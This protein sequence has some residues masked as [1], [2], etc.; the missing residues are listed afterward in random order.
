MRCHPF[1]KHVNSEHAGDV[2][3]RQMN[4][5]HEAFVHD[6][7]KICELWLERPLFRVLFDYIEDFPEFQWDVVVQIQ[8][9]KSGGQPMP[10][11]S[12]PLSPADRGQGAPLHTFRE[13]RGVIVNLLEH[14]YCRS[15]PFAVAWQ[16]R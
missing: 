4:K 16:R 8:H 15:S 3:R 5:L 12:E 14:I 7:G 6:Y 11:L 1:Q 10:A 2:L 13:T 9:S